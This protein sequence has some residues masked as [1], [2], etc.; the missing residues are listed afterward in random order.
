MEKHKNKPKRQMELTIR[1]ANV[2]SIQKKRIE[3]LDSLLQVRL[4]QLT[5]EERE[6][7]VQ[8][9]ST[10]PKS[11]RIENSGSFLHIRQD[12]LIKK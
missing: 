2:T 9:S 10:A 12:Q 1:T 11:N 4:A 3:K 5:K 8:H 7:Q 6:K